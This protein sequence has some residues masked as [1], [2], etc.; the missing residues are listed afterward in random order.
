[1]LSVGVCVFR[2]CIAIFFFTGRCNF[3]FPIFNGQ[4]ARQPWVTLGWAGGG[5]FTCHIKINSQLV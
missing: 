3:Q 5:A 1:M 2:V 4:L